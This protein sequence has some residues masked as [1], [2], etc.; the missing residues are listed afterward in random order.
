MES[1]YKSYQYIENLSQAECKEVTLRGW[2]M[3]KTG[4]GKLQF[5][6]LRD[7]TG[8]CQCVVFKPNVTEELFND[9]KALTQESSVM[10]TGNVRKEERAQGGYE[11]DVTGL[12]IMQLATDYPIT[13]KDHGDAFL[14][15]HRHLWLRSSRQHAIMRI[16]ASV[17]KAIRDFFEI[18]R[19]SCRERV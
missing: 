15:E 1:R 8:V 6:M 2:V 10:I 4:K 16:R 12:K 5:I 11:I 14:I 19:A 3:N 13:P 17:I 18:G 7:G 9:A